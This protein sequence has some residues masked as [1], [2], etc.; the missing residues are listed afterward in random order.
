[1]KS[2]AT[3]RAFLQSSAVAGAGA[4]LLRDS[5][6]AFG[7]QANDKLNVASIGVAEPRCVRRPLLRAWSTINTPGRGKD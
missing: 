3:R 1:M 2:R 7:Y 6:L 4:V 5:R